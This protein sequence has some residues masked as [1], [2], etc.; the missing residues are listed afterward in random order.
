MNIRKLLAD[1]HNTRLSI[2]QHREEYKDKP[3]GEI[4]A[5]RSQYLVR[6]FRELGNKITSIG[7]GFVRKYEIVV[8]MDGEIKKYEVN[9][10]QEIRPEDLEILFRTQNDYEDINIIGITIIS[11]IPLGVFKNKGK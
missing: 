9:Y 6:K 1:F 4:Y 5:R 11:E 10:T 3:K 8:V 2:I 7:S